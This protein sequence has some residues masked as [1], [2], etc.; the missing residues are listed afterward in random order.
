MIIDLQKHIKKKTK[1]YSIEDGAG[2]I[3]GVLQLYDGIDDYFEVHFF[4]SDVKKYFPVRS[5]DKIRISSNQSVLS[6]ALIDLGQKLNRKDFKFEL[7][8]YR[9]LHSKLDV[10]FIVNVIASL[11]N[12]NSFSDES[13]LMLSRC[14]SSLVL[15]V[16]HVYGTSIDNAKGIVGDHMRYVS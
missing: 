5:N 16:S 9:L 2:E 8:F 4:N 15:E 7:N 6:K 14:I 10:L 3:T 1:V 11:S 13:R 12:Q